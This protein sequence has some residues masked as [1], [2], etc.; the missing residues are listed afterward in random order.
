[1]SRAWVWVQLAIAWLPIWGLFAAIIVI[2]HG[3][4]FADAAIASAR[5]VVPGALLA[6]VLIAG[7]LRPVLLPKPRPSIKEHHVPSPIR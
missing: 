1:M 4:T 7:A 3:N 2:V 5:M 6:L